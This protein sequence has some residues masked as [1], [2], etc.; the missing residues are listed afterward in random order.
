MRVLD[1]QEA[2]DPE[3]WVA[4]QGADSEHAIEERA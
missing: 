3:A 2:A 4:V 1:L